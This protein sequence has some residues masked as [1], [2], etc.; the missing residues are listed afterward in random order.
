MMRIMS[1]MLL[2]VAA[3]TVQPSAGAAAELKVGDAVSGFRVT[4]V[5]ELPDFG[6][7]LW[8]MAYEK[9]GAELVWLDCT[10][11]NRTFVVFFKTI[12]SDD[13]GVAHIIEHSVLRGSEKYPVKEPFVELLKSSFAT[14]LNA[15]TASD[16]TSYPLATKNA[17]D[18]LNLA[19][20]YLDAV[21]HPLSVKDDWAMR[22]EGWHYEFDGT[23]LTRNGVV[24][25]EMKGACGSPESIAHL[26]LDRLLFPD[27]TYGRVS[28]GDPAHI[29]ELTF[30]AY[31]A[32]YARFYHPSNAR[33]FLYGRI[34]LAATLALIDTYIRPYERRPAEGAVPRQ[35]P[36]SGAKTLPYECSEKGNRTLLLDGWV[37]GTF[38][39]RERK[40]ATVILCNLLTGSNESPVKKAL[41]EAGLCEEAFFYPGGSEQ[42]V[43]YLM[44]KN[45]AE[46]RVEECRRTV[47]ETVGRLCREGLD[48]QRLS[49][50]IDRREF[51]WREMDTNQRG[52]V[53][54]S[55]VLDSWL[56]GGDPAQNMRAADFFRRLRE[57]IGTG[58]YERI[59]RE[60]LLENPHHAE[61]TLVPSATLADERR[62]QEREE[63]DKIKA[64]MSAEELARSA[65]E[66]KALKRRQSTPDRPED[67]ERLPRLTLAD[68]PLKGDVPQRTVGKVDGVTVLRPQVTTP[69]I[70]YLDFYFPLEGLSDDELLD[71]PFLASALCNLPTEHYTELEL[72]NELYGKLGDFRVWNATCVKGS[73]LAVRVSALE[74]RKDEMLRLAEEVLLRTKYDDAAAIGRLWAQR[75]ERIEREARSHGGGMAEIRAKRLLSASG[76]DE[77]L[78]GGLEQLQRMRGEI[79][80]K[81]LERLARRIFVLTPQKGLT[82]VAAGELTDGDVRRAI[83]IWPRREEELCT[84]SRRVFAGGDEGFVADGS[85]GYSALAC[86]LPENVP[87]AGSQLVAAKIVSLEHLWNEVRVKGGAY[88]GDL[89]VSPEGDVLFASWYDPNPAG[90]L[91][92]FRRSGEALKAFVSSG[93]PLMR[94]QIATAKSAEPNLSPSGRNWFVAIQYLNGRDP[95]SLQKLRREILGTKPAD[96]LSFAQTLSDLSA[97]ATAEVFANEKLLKPCGLD[98]IWTGR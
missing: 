77:E 32:F 2:V 61:V 58:W 85:V 93:A 52:L 15:W 1:R 59:L 47:R 62:K 27:N 20:V 10:D 12:P 66:A 35:K 89:T 81:E 55:S 9:N 48:A 69:G 97:Q 4:A 36:V 95:E 75:R 68:I 46:G 18:F 57:R 38:D 90:S 17:R 84:G 73:Y 94:Y 71:V 54:Y 53:A 40:V 24:Y 44:A 41:L 51:Y 87:F 19:D 3:L 74:S 22:Q 92:H 60:A 98:R 50:L 34:D 65:A 21:F 6:G 26:E 70:V 7:R 78:F 16:C 11:E 8:R 76:H 25:S 39:D 49:A 28:G 88:G 82:V 91:G 33:F 96:V 13:T 56:Y 79:S 31:K 37:T 83:A 63:L 43:L 30:E 67:I 64:G 42:K 29:P 72:Q 14:Y 23:N 5:T 86:R 45:V 80:G